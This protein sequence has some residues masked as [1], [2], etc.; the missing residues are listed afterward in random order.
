[1]DEKTESF[2]AHIIFKGKPDRKILEKVTRNIFWMFRIEKLTET[3]IA[4]KFCGEEKIAAKIYIERFNNTSR[5]QAK[6]TTTLT[7]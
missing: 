7:K 5:Y 4:E 3:V 6:A 1:M 2:V